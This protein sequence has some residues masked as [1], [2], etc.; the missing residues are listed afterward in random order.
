MAELP[1]DRLLQAVIPAAALQ[2]RKKSRFGWLLAGCC[3]AASLAACT[4][5]PSSEW[6]SGLVERLYY[7][8]ATVAN[9][10]VRCIDNMKGSVDNGVAV[11]RIRVGR[12]PYDVALPFDLQLALATGDRV[13]VELLSCRITRSLQ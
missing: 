1:N 3:A 12:A 2:T 11:V 13:S 9:A 4:S 5:L 6:R 7:G 10:D 8:G